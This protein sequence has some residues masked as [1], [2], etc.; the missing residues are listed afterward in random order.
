MFRSILTLLL[1]VPVVFCKNRS[2]RSGKVSRRSRKLG[3]K[4]GKK[5]EKKMVQET[6]DLVDSDDINMALAPLWLMD[7][8]MCG[9]TDYADIP[10]LPMNLAGTLFTDSGDIS[11]PRE[12]FEKEEWE[13]GSEPLWYYNLECTLLETHL[14]T[15]LSQIIQLMPMFEVPSFQAGVEYN[16]GK[17]EE[18]FFLSEEGLAS[19]L[20]GLAFEFN[21][22]TPPWCE[23]KIILDDGSGAIELLEKRMFDAESKTL[24]DR[25]A[26]EVRKIGREDGAIELTSKRADATSYAKSR[27]PEVSEKIYTANFV[28]KEDMFRHAVPRESVKLEAISLPGMV[29]CNIDACLGLD[30]NGTRNCIY[31]RYSGYSE[32]LLSVKALP[33][34]E[35]DVPPFIASVISGTGRFAGAMGEAE[36]TFDSEFKEGTIDLRYFPSDE[37]SGLWH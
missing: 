28:T 29:S 37:M 16:S 23:N 10:F 14:E 1:F 32:A 33:H 13:K 20:Y 17:I 35:V 11:V 26:N 31:L 27:T 4:P 7:L 30:D 12:E 22:E 21:M 19:E 8:V 6:I 5:H 25:K 18:P 36:V 15:I 24:D 2:L 3:G 9:K 34:V